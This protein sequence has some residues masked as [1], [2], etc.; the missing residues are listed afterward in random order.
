MIAHIIYIIALA[1]SVIWFSMGFYYFSFQQN[2][3]AKILIPK[4]ARN[5][6]LFSTMAAAIRFLG[7]MNAAFALLTA[8]LF[9]LAVSGSAMFTAP[10]ERAVLLFV[11]AAT[12]FSQFYFNVPILKNG[13]RQGESFWPVLSG[14]MRTIFITDAAQTIL[15]IFAGVL[16]II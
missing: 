9:F 1:A 8:A 10:I 7:G 16:Q 2:T 15:C 4:S 12:H 5:S 3:A 14:P 13:E 6:P 11:I